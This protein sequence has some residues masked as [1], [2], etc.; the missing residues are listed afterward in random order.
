[1]CLNLGKPGCSVERSW[2]N[3]LSV[4]KCLGISK[5]KRL[6]WCEQRPGAC[7]PLMLK[8]VTPRDSLA[9]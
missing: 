5:D 8:L 7:L 1:M 3:V 2:G 6:R 9:G 4:G